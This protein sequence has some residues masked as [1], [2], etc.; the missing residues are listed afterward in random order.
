MFPEFSMSA[1]YEEM[2]P[3]VGFG[4]TLI[5]GCKD[6]P[7]PDGFDQYKRKLLRKMR[8]RETLAQITQ[9]I[10]TYADFFQN[11]G[12]D[13]P[14]T[15]HLKRTVN[16][17]FP[18]YSLFVDAHFMA[19]MCA[20]ILVAVT[21]FDRFDG[22]LTLDAADDGE[23]CAGMGGREFIMQDGEIMLRDEKEIVC[24]LAQGADEKTRV[25]EDTSN[26]LLYAYAVPGIDRQYLKNGL[27]VGAETVVEFGGGR[28]EG[29][30][31]F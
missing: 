29:I 5:S 19:E 1:R 2:Y 20:G 25:R 28:I 31:I 10:N 17:G 21:D 3:G 7:N 26:V 18:R 13:C 8:K 6:H 12:Y 16:S 4:L 14:L 22:N 24:V 27:T 9:R 15:K 30:E 11:F 23:V